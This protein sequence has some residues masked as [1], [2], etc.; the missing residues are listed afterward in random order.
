MC[1]W[2]LECEWTQ[3]SRLSLSDSLRVPIL[4]L[5]VPGLSFRVTVLINEALWACS[6][7][8]RHPDGSP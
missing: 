6:L 3:S 1:H 4:V 2:E 8:P 5:H 7:G